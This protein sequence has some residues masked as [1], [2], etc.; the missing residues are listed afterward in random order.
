MLARFISDLFFMDSK[1][2]KNLLN[3]IFIRKKQLIVTLSFYNRF[4][5]ENNKKLAN[6]CLEKRINCLGNTQKLF[7]VP[8]MIESEY[9]S[10]LNFS[11]IHL[12]NSMHV[13]WPDWRIFFRNDGNSSS[14]I[15]ISFFICQ[16]INRDK[17]QWDRFIQTEHF[18]WESIKTPE[19]T[20]YYK[21]TTPCYYSQ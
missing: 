11:H 20:I 19:T 1:F 9:K 15:C 14:L 4:F 12:I 17:I 5:F 13:K 8:Q 2:A 6:L 10:C 7:F 21:F 18:D 3:S 16:S